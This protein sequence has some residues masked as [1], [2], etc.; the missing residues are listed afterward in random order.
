MGGGLIP[1]PPA[2]RWSGGG[3]PWPLKEEQVGGE[4]GGGGKRRPVEREELREAGGARG[5]LSV[6]PT[7][8]TLLNPQFPAGREE[9]TQV[10]P[11]PP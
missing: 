6:H 7:F 5:G 1:L 2:R 10:S 9:G 11:E 4:Q 8:P 3:E